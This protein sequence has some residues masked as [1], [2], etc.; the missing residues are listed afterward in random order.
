MIGHPVHCPT[1]EDLP[2]PP[3]GKTGWPWTT[4]CPRLPQSMQDGQPWPKISIVTPSFN[5]A[6]Y[7]EE[8]IRSILLQGYPELEYLVIDG[9]ST[10]GSG[11]IIRKY[12]RW[13]SYWVSE[14]DNGQ[15]SAINKGLRR[16]TGELFNW[17]N[18]DDA[19]QP[20]GLQ[21]VAESFRRE[22]DKLIAG[23]VIYHYED[24][25]EEQVVR[26]DNV[27]LRPMVEFW[28]NRASFHQPG[29]FIPVHQMKRA[30]ELDEGLEYALD[31]DL[32]CR[33]LS[34]VQVNYVRQPV[35]M[36]RVH[37]ASKSESQSHRFLPEVYEA[38]SRYWTSTPHLAWPPSDPKGAG[39][40]FRVGCWQILHKDSKGFTRIKEA[41]TS[42][43][44]VALSST[45]FFFPGW[46]QRRWV[47]KK[48][49][50][51]SSAPPLN[52]N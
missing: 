35:A 37:P 18:S 38:S 22:P 17:I 44:I 16:I 47:R 40:S 32:F 46:I 3:A 29:I 11:E 15:S 5:Q 20:Y 19:L 14:P 2:P 12:E 52:M 7:L 48:Q 51:H 23:D 28:N 4:A 1:L 31:Y 9:G 25:R 50:L 33:L 30:G 34:F 45:L 49:L 43:P 6:D 41:L 39:L 8:T 10:D 26:Q 36:Y 13:L 27:E 42:D 24:S 21:A